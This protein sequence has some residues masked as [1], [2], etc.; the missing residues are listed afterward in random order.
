[1]AERRYLFHK[2]FGDNRT[3]STEV[4]ESD[5]TEAQKNLL[6]AE[7]IKKFGSMAFDVEDKFVDYLVTES[8]KFQEKNG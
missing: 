1:M 6:V 3:V 7:L 4:N 2:N 5:L 8:N